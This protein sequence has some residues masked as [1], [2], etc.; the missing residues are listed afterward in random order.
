MWCRSKCAR[1]TVN[2]RRKKKERKRERKRETERKKRE[3]EKKIGNI[4]TACPSMADKT[5]ASHVNEWQRDDQEEE[6]ENEEEENEEY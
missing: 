5:V 4:F 2:P 6:E 1:G 3:R